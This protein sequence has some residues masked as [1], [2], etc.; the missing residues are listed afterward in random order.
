MPDKIR[1]AVIPA[2]GLG[3][4][5]LPTT[6]AVPK[7]LLPLLDQPLIQYGV[8]EAVEAGIERVVIVTSPGKD[9]LER[10]F[11]SDAGLEPTSC[12]LRRRRPCP[13]DKQVGIPR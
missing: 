5:F 8:E 9:A 1:T 12:R 3:T 7:E 2:A 11:S 10:Y 4:R 13:A 6:K